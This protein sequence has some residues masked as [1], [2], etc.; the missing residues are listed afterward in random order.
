MGKG[1]HREGRTN[2]SHSVNSFTTSSRTPVRTPLPWRARPLALPRRPQ[3]R[4][5][6]VQ[7]CETPRR[8]DAQARAARLPRKTSLP[9]RLE[10]VPTVPTT[11]R[12]L[13]LFREMGP[14]AGVPYLT[15]RAGTPARRSD[16]VAADGAKNGVC[17]TGQQGRYGRFGAVW[18]HLVC[19]DQRW[20]S[21]RSR[22]QRL[23]KRDQRVGMHEGRA[24]LAQKTSEVSEVRGHAAQ[25]CRRARRHHQRSSAVAQE[26]LLA[27]VPVSGLLERGARDPGLGAQ[28]E[29]DQ[30]ACSRSGT[31][32]NTALEAPPSTPSWKTT[33]PRRD[34][35]RTGELA[36]QSVRSVIEDVHFGLR[37]GE[38][39]VSQHPRGRG[40][41]SSCPPP[42]QSR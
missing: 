9:L 28:N 10:M 20:V 16:C 7:S 22:D 32:L 23:G 37:C 42:F 11:S 3:G 13:S 25:S 27:A 5:R 33:A 26:P 29:N 6:T 18:E 14:G 36:E 39:R 34:W 15:I 30:P 19:V 1:H 40:S 8:I 24:L 2:R 17:A 12:F 41:A 31:T 4:S 38:A 21:S 35:S